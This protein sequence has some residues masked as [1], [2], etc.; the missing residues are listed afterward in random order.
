MSIDGLFRMLMDAELVAG[1]PQEK[2]Y[3]RHSDVELMFA[4]S[5]KYS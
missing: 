3:L 2:A 1:D 5:A 4:K